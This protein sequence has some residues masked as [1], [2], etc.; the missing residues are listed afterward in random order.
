MGRSVLD[1]VSCAAAKHVPVLQLHVS[2]VIRLLI[3]P[4]ASEAGAE[5][6]I[7]G[8]TAPFPPRR[9]WGGL[10]AWTGSETGWSSS[11]RSRGNLNGSPASPVTILRRSSSVYSCRAAGE[12]ACIGVVAKSR[13]HW[14]RP[15]EL[16]VIFSAARRTKKQIKS[17]SA[18]PFC[19]YVFWPCTI[20][21][22]R[23]PQKK[24]VR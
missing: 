15:E 11:E 13:G 6:G 3:L 12:E 10:S 8:R 1:V 16:L 21:Q 9:C 18:P 19:I 24:G 22:K 5:S 20:Y 2:P 23:C 7:G 17:R 14:S 4:L